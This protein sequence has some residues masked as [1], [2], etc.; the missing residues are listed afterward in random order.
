M[1]PPFSLVVAAVLVL[2]AVLI[3][4]VSAV[5]AAAVT[6]E[7][8]MAIHIAIIRLSREKIFTAAGVAAAILTSLGKMAAKES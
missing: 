2:V 4:T 7:A 1:T 8:N 5:Q 3:C 6:V